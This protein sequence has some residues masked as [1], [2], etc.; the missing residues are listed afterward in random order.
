MPRIKL[1]AI[2]P[3][4]APHLSML[5]E[6]PSDVEVTVG[7]SEEEL[8]GPIADADVIFNGMGKGDLLKVLLPHAKAVRWIHS[9]SAGVEHLM[10]PAIVDSPVPLTNARG[11]FAESLGE[12]VI[13]AALYFAKHFPRMKRSQAEGKWDVFDVDMLSRQSMAIVG[14]GEIGRAAARR[15]KALG[16]K[17]YATRRRPELLKD[18]PV[19]DEG[20]SPADRVAM[21]AKA[22]Y[23][24]AAA[25]I[26]PET[27]GLIGEKEF[28]AMKPNAVV[29]NV[30][31]GPVLDEAGMV[32]AL[33]EKRIRG[34]ALDVFDVE[35]LPPGH[36]F[37]SMENV[38]LSP[39]TA[40]HVEGWM[41]DAMRFFIE[42]FGRFYR[43]EPLQNIVDKKAGY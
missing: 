41:D 18:D 30:G 15:A 17:V 5:K 26:T 27:R 1:V 9:M 28:A 4:N 6:L 19:V 12:F 23:V 25:A 37:W 11:V 14:Y 3:P 2:S 20:F 33:Q 8:A 10:F 42:N 40:D 32:K 36:P 24:V 35:P 29:M 38:L 31:R 39:H 22:D 7:I 34:A 16:M 43:G 21:I 13:A